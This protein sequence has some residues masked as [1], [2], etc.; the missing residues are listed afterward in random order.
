MHKF[1]QYS[2][3]QWHE[4]SVYLLML[5]T[6]QLLCSFIKLSTVIDE[7]WLPSQRDRD[8]LLRECRV[9][10]FNDAING[11]RDDEQDQA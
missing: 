10:A 8:R 6:K 2:V 3:R 4:I 11:L 5:K 9:R 7:F 1:D